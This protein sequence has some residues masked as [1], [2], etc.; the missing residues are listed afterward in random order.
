MFSLIFNEFSNFSVFVLFVV[1]WLR[2]RFFPF[3]T[4]R[5][6]IFW[7]FWT[8]SVYENLFFPPVTLSSYIKINDKSDITIMTGKK[9]QWIDSDVF[10]KNDYL[11]PTSTPFSCNIYEFFDICAFHSRM[12]FWTM[13]GY[14]GFRKSYK[15]NHLMIW[16]VTA[17]TFLPFCL[18]D[19]YSKKYAQNLFQW[20]EG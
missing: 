7:D 12:I 16:L 13:T 17:L 10:F 6:W 19:N 9:A 2:H 11:L 8:I 14:N 1:L 4:I 5:L 3:H 15:W 18:Q 20:N